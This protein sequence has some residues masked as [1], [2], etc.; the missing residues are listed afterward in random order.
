M[1]QLE[2][3]SIIGA[4]TLRVKDIK[5]VSAF[6]EEI[7]GLH[8]LSS[9]GDR[10]SLGTDQRALVKLRHTPDGRRANR[11][12]GL[13][14]LALRV[15]TRQDL[16][17]WLQHYINAGNP[18]F[19]G[20]SDHLVSEALYLSDSEGNGIEIY[21]DKPTAVWP[22]QPDGGLRMAVDP[23]DLGDILAGVHANLWQ[24]LPA[25]TDM[26]HAHLQV[27]NL[28]ATHEYYINQL[29]LNVMTAFGDS[30]LFVSVGGYHHH[31]GLNTWHSLGTPPANPNSLGL[32]SVEVIL[33]DDTISTIAERVVQHEEITYEEN[34]AIALTDPSGN[35][36]ILLSEI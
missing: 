5:R 32:E 29:G 19:Q 35:R 4:I 11:A 7:I 16:G 34:G 6:Y 12:P 36:L 17:A 31:F 21:W 14:H 26:G 9:E 2:H 33:D 25:Q 27:S 18:N 20:A 3:P 30:A 8:V 24:G 28:N 22:M 1:N 13:Y 10:V 15:P 23:L